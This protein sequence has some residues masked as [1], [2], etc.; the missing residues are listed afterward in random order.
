MAFPEGLIWERKHE[1]VCPT[2]GEYLHSKRSLKKHRGNHRSGG[3]KCQK[4]PS[5]NGPEESFV[6]EMFKKE[7]EA[8]KY[9]LAMAPDD[10]FCYRVNLDKRKCKIKNCVAELRKR[11]ARRL[12]CVEGK[13]DVINGHAVLG[14]LY[15][16]PELHCNMP[17]KKKGYCN[18]QHDNHLIINE[19]FTSKPEA[20][21]KV[22][23]LLPLT[24]TENV[25]KRSTVIYK[26]SCHSNC[27][28]RL[29]VIEK[30]PQVILLRGC[31]T[32]TNIP[33]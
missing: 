19:T 30:A 22:K 8:D 7:S 15:H 3:N 13:W 29:R 27:G 9:L 1:Q 33:T 16:S 14:T 6:N 10:S 18:L 28:A 11:K 23:S 25:K 2:C 5:T 31:V 24:E 26:C 20:I 17:S 32:H 21:S 4:V 12:C